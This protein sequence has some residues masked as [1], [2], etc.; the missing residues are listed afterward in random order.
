L[1]EGVN[2]QLAVLKI[3]VG[4]PDGFAVMEATW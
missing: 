4:Y 3:L 2:I 1:R